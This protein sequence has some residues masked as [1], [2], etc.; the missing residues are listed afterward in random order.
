VH[1]PQTAPLEHV[2]TSEFSPLWFQWG[3]HWGDVA[4]VV[5]CYLFN[6]NAFCY[7]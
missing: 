3:P 4:S 5:S 6:R 2:Q 7:F 1:R